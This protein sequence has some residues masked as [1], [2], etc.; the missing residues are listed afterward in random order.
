MC[1]SSLVS[2]PVFDVAQ[3]G[4]VVFLFADS[5]SEAFERFGLVYQRVNH[6]LTNLTLVLRLEI[7]ANLYNLK[8]VVRGYVPCGLL[9]RSFVKHIT[10][11]K[12]K[13]NLPNAIG[14]L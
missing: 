2:L 6:R 11:R 4:C 14:N 3:C 10:L 12:G 9:H 1:H 8:M 7:Q 5:R 13:R